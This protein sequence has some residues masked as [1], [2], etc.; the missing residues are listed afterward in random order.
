MELISLRACP[1]SI[2]IAGLILDK[3]TLS[4]WLF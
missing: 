3:N 1:T 4:T 2:V